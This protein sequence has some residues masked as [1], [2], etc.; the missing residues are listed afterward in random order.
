MTS[1]PNPSTDQTSLSVISLGTLLGLLLMAIRFDMM[2]YSWTGYFNPYYLF[3]LLQTSYYDLCT[4]GIAAA[5][6]VILVRACRGRACRGRARRVVYGLFAIF[7]FTA[8]VFAVVNH[9]AIGMLGVP[10]NFQW[11]EYS[12]F[13][14]SLDAKQALLAKFSW[15][16]VLGFLGLLLALF[17]GARV[18][19]SMLAAPKRRQQLTRV[20]VVACVLYFPFMTYWMWGNKSYYKQ[21]NGVVAM[22]ESLFVA[23][24]PSIFTMPTDIGDADFAIV[25]ERI[26]AQAPPKVEGIRNVIF[27]VLE[28]TAAEYVSTYGGQYPVTPVLEKVKGRSRTF[29]AAYAHAPTTNKSMVSM[30]CSVYPWI[31]T[32]ALTKRYP[33]NKMVSLA[34]V[35]GEQ[36]YRTG[37]FNS[38]DIRHQGAGRFLEG[39]QFQIVEDYRTRETDLE[40]YVDPDGYEMMNSSD[41]LA[42]TQSLW[43]WIEQ[44]PSRPFFGVVWTM[45]THYPYYCRGKQVDYGAKRRGMN[46]YLNA[47]RHA[48]SCLGELLDMLDAT[49]LADSTLVVVVGDHGEAFG[50]HRFNYAHA[51]H[52]Y[53]EN[54]H[55]PLVLIHPRL[56]KGG[57]SDV[58]CGIVDLAPTV[59]DV[60]DLPFPKAWQ[61]RSLLRKWERERIY[62][63]SPWSHKL[64]GFREGDLKF[65]YNARQ[66]RIRAYD[67]ST[68]PR[69]RKN[70]LSSLPPNTG[71]VVKRKL[72]AW[73]RYQAKVMQQH[74]LK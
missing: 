7:S 28:S 61:G 32:H 73:T 56:F 67:L 43:K 2:G 49:K 48:D 14:T 6:S 36:G 22:V 62:F 45:G 12:D 52:L 37:F 59:L 68:D 24:E 17:G 19:R 1:S 46:K 21:A 30:F 41:D 74:I 42:T 71:D 65:I 35:L 31:S 38:A 40:G 55:V 13:L 69:E 4:V 3:D 63:F 60:L 50:Q 10:A 23:E 70:I 18:L 34:E 27:F 47:M 54:V 64:F 16:L 25:A 57:T 44:E 39:L 11:L 5:I 9:E 58:L 33:D 29:T 72:A 15:W 20:G 53:E 51:Q 8:L 66:D 26:P